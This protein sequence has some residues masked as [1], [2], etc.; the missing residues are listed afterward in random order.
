LFGEYP[1]HAQGEALISGAVTPIIISELQ[2]RIPEEYIELNR[3]AEKLEDYF[4]EMQDIEF[5]I[6]SGKLYMLQ[7]RTGKRTS[8]A[9]VKIAVDMAKAEVISTKEAII[10]I[11]PD[12]LKGLLHKSVSKPEAF[13]AIGRGLTAAPGA[14]SGKVVFDPMEAIIAGQ[15]RIIFSVPY[16]CH[17]NDKDMCPQEKLSRGKYPE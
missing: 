14:V 7:T 9:A 13:V 3:M 6:E 4:K 11:S 12:D 17:Q 1:S 2:K 10:R 8:R 16:I 5:T 15:Y